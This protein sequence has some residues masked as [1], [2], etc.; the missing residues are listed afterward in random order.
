MKYKSLS[1][2]KPNGS[3]IRDGKKTIEVRSWKPDIPLGEDLLIIE[4]EKRLDREGEVDP[5]GKAV[6]IVKIKNVR[7]FLESDIE[8]AFASSWAPNY[9]SWELEDIRPLEDGEPLLAARGI[10]EL[11]V[12]NRDLGD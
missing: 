9:Y 1:L 11:D 7:E 5:N 8:A 2:V 3:N 10:Y 12:S 4:N 6:A